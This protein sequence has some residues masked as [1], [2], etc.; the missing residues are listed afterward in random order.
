M[1]IGPKL[2]YR[3]FV[4]NGILR[5]FQGWKNCTLVSIHIYIH[6]RCPHKAKH[7][8]KVI[9]HVSG[10]TEL[11]NTT[12]KKKKKKIHLCTKKE[13]SDLTKLA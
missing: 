11:V 13:H 5:T 10:F 7:V 1:L 3:F 8:I 2:V 4:P 6:N 9:F 12:A